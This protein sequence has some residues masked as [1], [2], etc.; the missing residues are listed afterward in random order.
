MVGG[1]AGSPC[2]QTFRQRFAVLKKSDEARTC[3]K[4][5]RA[6]HGE[7]RSADFFNT[8]V[9]VWPQGL[10]AW[11][12][13]RTTEFA[14]LKAQLLSHLSTMTK[15]QVKLA[16]ALPV[17]SAENIM[18]LSWNQKFALRVTKYLRP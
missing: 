5:R 4:P 11:P 3:L 14:I 10:P 15:I 6:A 18:A 17:V 9:A 13:H 8:A 12:T 7:F 16:V 1:Q 2:G